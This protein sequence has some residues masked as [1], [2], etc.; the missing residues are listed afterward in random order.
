MAKTVIQ[1]RTTQSVAR[2]IKAHG[3]K[4]IRAEYAELRKIANKRIQ[5]A[6]AQ[7]ELSDV[8]LF[9]TTR[10]VSTDLS[11]LA[12]EYS[13]VTKFLTSKRSTAA[14]RAESKRKT[15]KSLKEIGYENVSERN[16]DLFNSFMENFRRKYEM[17]TPEGKKLLMDSDFA[18]EVFDVISEDFTSRTN[19]RSMSRM[20]NNYLR[21]NGM[22]DYIVKL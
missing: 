13:A 9:K 22:H 3:T 18:L 6:Q 10:E 5:R 16:V 17:D 19:S 1:R 8:P 14:G 2:E 15:V 11:R 7:G 4:K 20:F 21:D 12:K